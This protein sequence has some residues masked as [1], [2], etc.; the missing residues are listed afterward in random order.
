[1]SY[2]ITKTN[3]TVLGVI[4]DGTADTSKTSL[5]LVGRNYSN[6]G[7]IMTDNLVKLVENF[8]YNI[9]PSNPLAGQLWWDTA[10]AK[11]NVYTGTAFKVI[12][13]VVSQSSAPSTPVI[14][15]LWLDTTNTQVYIYAGT[16]W[17]LVGPSYS[18]INGK[19][20]AIW[21]TIADSGANLRHVVSLYI[22][23]V[24]M[25][26]ISENLV[27]TPL[28]PI[29]G[30]ATIQKGYNLNSGEVFY[31]NVTNSAALG[32]IA[33]SYYVRNDTSNTITGNLRITN[34]AGI[35]LGANLDLTISNNAI[36]NN[37]SNAT[38][39][40]YSNIG[41]VL[42]ATIAIAGATGIVTVGGVQVATQPYV[43]AK[44]VNTV[45]T[46]VPIAPTAAFGVTGNTQV[47]TT[48]FVQA[49]F[50]RF[51]ISQGNSDFTITD[52]GTGSATLTIDGNGVL[53]ATVSGVNLSNGATATT[54][55]QVYNSTGNAAVATTSYVNTATTW[56]GGSAKIVSTLAPDNGVGNNGDF[57]FT[58]E[59]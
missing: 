22:D 59:A 27:F 3:G 46:G 42:T 17:I 4:L 28:I 20:G 35:T 48:A 49:A 32:N 55:T 43:D 10:S 26:I 41:G 30:F 23:G 2:T 45:M 12:S 11:L 39:T 7:Q 51:R 54:Q 44:F 6:Y 16:G 53:T 18:T 31:G 25:S 57:W 24:R 8:A 34:N 56:W 58:R 36:T 47:A 15:D 9:S 52:S 19:S 33:A 13:S 38:T 37:I 1:M 50:D 40:F 21:E 5:T 29:T 14:G